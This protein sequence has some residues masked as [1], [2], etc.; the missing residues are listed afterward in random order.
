[1]S[2]VKR[3]IRSDKGMDRGQVPLACLVQTT[4]TPQS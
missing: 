4:F 3:R 1:L 2:R